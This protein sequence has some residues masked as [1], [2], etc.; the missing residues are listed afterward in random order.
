MVL[1]ALREE[2]TQIRELILKGAA[3]EAQELLP[4]L[5]EKYSEFQEIPY[6]NMI[7][8]ILELVKG[9]EKDRSTDKNE[10]IKRISYHL[11]SIDQPHLQHGERIAITDLINDLIRLRGEG[12]SFREK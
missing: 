11:Q 12:L 10:L 3:E 8:S 2:A 5:Y 6:L 9:T 7:K 4:K 1:S